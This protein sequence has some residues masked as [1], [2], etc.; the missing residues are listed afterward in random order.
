MKI[1]LLYAILLAGIISCN[2]ETSVVNPSETRKSEEVLN[3]EKSIKSLS[4]PENRETAEEIRNKKSIELSDRR[5]DILIPSALELIKSTG[6][7][8]KDI[9]ENT[10]GDRDKILTWA[11]KIYNEKLE[12]INQN[13]KK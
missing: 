4:N 1:K 7:K 5:K 13:S 3:F 10:Q 6:A 8:D 2:T 12:K 9:T 11:V